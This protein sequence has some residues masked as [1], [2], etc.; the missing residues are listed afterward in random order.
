VWFDSEENGGSGVCNYDAGVTAK[1]WEKDGI[2]VL[3][4]WIR[5]AEKSRGTP[6][7]TRQVHL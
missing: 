1:I 5:P 3:P 4:A 2:Y 6:G 7:F